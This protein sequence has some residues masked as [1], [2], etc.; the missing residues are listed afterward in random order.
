MII[1]YYTNNGNTA[2]TRSVANTNGMYNVTQSN[3]K[4]VKY[5]NQTT[6]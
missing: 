3:N 2:L 1:D 6:N 5:V 4:I